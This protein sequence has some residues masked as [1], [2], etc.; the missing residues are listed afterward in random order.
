MLKFPKVARRPRE[1]EGRR[2]ACGRAQRAAHECH[3]GS[4]LRTHDLRELQPIPS[5]AKAVQRPGVEISLQLL[6]GQRKVQD[7]DILLLAR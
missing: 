3:V 7:G 5:Q 4:L 2:G 6:E 1:L